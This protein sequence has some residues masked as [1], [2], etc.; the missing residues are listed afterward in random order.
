MRYPSIAL[1]GDSITRGIDYDNARGRYAVMRQHVTRILENRGIIQIDNHARFGATV[2][3]GIKDFESTACVSA[4]HVAIQFG[5]NDCNMP[6]EAIASA[7]DEDHGAAVPLPLFEETLGRF[8]AL[9]RERG[10]Q[11]ILVTP[12]PLIAQRFFAWVSKG[13]DRRA[14]R[15]FLGDVQHIYRWQER[16][17]LAV[18]RAAAAEGCLLFD[19]RDALLAS[20]RYPTLCGIDGMHL[21]ERGHAW[22]ADAVARALPVLFK[23]QPKARS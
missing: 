9:V 15:R 18:R 20:R 7:P 14:I 6:W 16:Y 21:N 10:K 19:L 2:L 8:V 17:G 4:E 22:L 12:P 11:P 1:W 3:D 23:D 5:G 13:L